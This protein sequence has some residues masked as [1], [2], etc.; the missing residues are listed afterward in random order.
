[1]EYFAT[2]LAALLTSYIYLFYSFDD[3]WTQHYL[4][5]VESRR[6]TWPDIQPRCY[7]GKFRVIPLSMRI[8]PTIQPL[9]A[10]NHCA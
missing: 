8:Q 6:K 9:V 10:C 2:V 3:R 5:V 7:A 4:P 1:M